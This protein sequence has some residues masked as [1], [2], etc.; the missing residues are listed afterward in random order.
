MRVY[1]A[2]LAVRWFRVRKAVKGLCSWLC[3]GH[4]SEAVASGGPSRVV[5]RWV[6]GD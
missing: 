4:K 1:G 6:G 3:D 2:L 5:G